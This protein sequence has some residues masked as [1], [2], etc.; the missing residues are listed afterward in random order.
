MVLL[1]HVWLKVGYQPNQLLD[2]NMN[3]HELAWI[4]NSHV[5]HTWWRW[6][7]ATSNSGAAIKFA[8]S[9]PASQGKLEM[10]GC[11]QGLAV[12]EVRVEDLEESSTVQCRDVLLGVFLGTATA[13]LEDV[14]KMTLWLLY[15][16]CQQAEQG[17]SVDTQNITARLQTF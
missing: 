3:L 7:Q 5:N 2:T 9:L 10:A 17:W 6:H 15:F 1:W 8:A 16:L 13:T 4:N 14:D 11:F 12:W